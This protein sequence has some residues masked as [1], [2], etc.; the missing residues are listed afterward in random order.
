MGNVKYRCRGQFLY[1][2]NTREI[3]SQVIQD[4]N[5]LNNV[6]LWRNLL[7]VIRPSW[8]PEIEKAPVLELINMWLDVKYAR[9][10]CG[11]DLTD[12][13]ENKVSKLPEGEHWIMCP[14]CFNQILVVRGKKNNGNKNR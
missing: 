7:T 4:L 6:E 5:K 8:K 13:F 12:K 3:Y 9:K 1:D 11:Y 14:K 10:G 2:S